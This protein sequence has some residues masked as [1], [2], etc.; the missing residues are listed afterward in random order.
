M[1]HVTEVSDQSGPGQ[2]GVNA[3]RLRPGRNSFRNNSGS[4]YEGIRDHIE[5]T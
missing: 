1:F 5:R 2:Q 3:E 4:S